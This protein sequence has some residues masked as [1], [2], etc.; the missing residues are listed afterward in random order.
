[1]LSF[2]WDKLGGRQ[3][4]TPERIAINL[5]DARIADNENN[6]PIRFP[7]QMMEKVRIF[8]HYRLKQW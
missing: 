4:I 1:M 7:I 8:Q 5:D 6:Q 2:V 3:G